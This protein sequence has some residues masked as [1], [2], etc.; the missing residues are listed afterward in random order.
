MCHVKTLWHSLFTFLFIYLKMWDISNACC[1]VPI[2]R[3]VIYWAQNLIDHSGAASTTNAF[4]VAAK[5]ETLILKDPGLFTLLTSG[6]ILNGDDT[7]VPDQDHSSF[8]VRRRMTP[9]HVNKALLTPNSWRTWEWILLPCY[10]N[11]EFPEETDQYK[12]AMLPCPYLP[13][14]LFF[15]PK[16]LPVLNFFCV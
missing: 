5:I 9:C 6:E 13:I 8:G 4:T 11:N 1:T 7:S 2:S 12:L 15:V 3:P 16:C 14:S 10:P